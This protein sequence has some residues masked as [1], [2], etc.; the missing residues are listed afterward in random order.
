MPESHIGLICVQHKW[1]VS[2][3]Y[4]KWMRKSVN[5]LLMLHLRSLSLRYD[6]QA[7]LDLKGGESNGARKCSYA[8]WQSKHLML[9]NQRESHD[10][11]SNTRILV[12]QPRISCEKVC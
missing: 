11:I 2:K 1:L 7:F 4:Y 3:E 9:S 6:I 5:V 12:W 10:V 8:I